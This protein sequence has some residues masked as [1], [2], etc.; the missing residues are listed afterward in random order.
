MISALLPSP[1]VLHLQIQSFLPSNNPLYWSSAFPLSTL[2]P[3][4]D[5][6]VWTGLLSL[7][8]NWLPCIPSAAGPSNSFTLYMESSRSF[9]KVRSHPSLVTLFSGFLLHPE[10]NPNSSPQ[11]QRPS[12]TSTCFPLSP[13]LIPLFLILKL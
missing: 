1:Q 13:P 10:E 2:Q 5:T 12:M 6:L 4:Q 8:L 9:K 7:P 11:H 3:G